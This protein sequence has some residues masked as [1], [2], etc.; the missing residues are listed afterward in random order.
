[1]LRDRLVCGL[2]NERMQ[3]RLLAKATLTFDKALKMA[4]AFE[5][6][7]LNA[8]VL[9]PASEAPVEVHTTG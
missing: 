8:R 4:Q 3:R 1:M 5:T 7:E 2:R 9:R 6:A